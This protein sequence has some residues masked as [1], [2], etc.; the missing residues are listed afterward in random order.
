MARHRLV[1]KKL[2]QLILILCSNSLSGNPHDL[3][4]LINE[5]CTLLDAVPTPGEAARNEA[6]ARKQIVAAVREFSSRT[7]RL[8]GQLVESYRDFIIALC[9]AMLDFVTWM[10]RLQAWRRFVVSITVAADVFFRQMI[11]TS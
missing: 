9:D 4:L 10:P 5:F 3:N 8:L 6:Q 11:E 1:Y 2:Y 7:V